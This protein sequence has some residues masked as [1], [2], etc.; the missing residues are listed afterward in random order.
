MKISS[1]NRAKKTSKG[2]GLMLIAFIIGVTLAFS[3]PVTGAEKKGS[4]KKAVINK[5]N[6]SFDPNVKSATGLKRKA[7]T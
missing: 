7:E 1:V 3:M 2:Y 4:D 5:V 6:S